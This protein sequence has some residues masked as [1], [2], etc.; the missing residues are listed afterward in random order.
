MLGRFDSTS[1]IHESGLQNAFIT[2]VVVI[3]SLLHSQ[4]RSRIVFQKNRGKPLDYHYTE[5]LM[6]Y[7]VCSQLASRIRNFS[8]GVN[9]PGYNQLRQQ[10][11]AQ[12]KQDTAVPSALP[13]Q[14]VH[15]LERK[16]SLISHLLES[17]QPLNLDENEEMRSVSGD[18]TESFNTVS[19]SEEEFES[20]GTS[21]DSEK[22]EKEEKEDEGV[23]SLMCGEW[24][25]R[26]KEQNTLWGREEIVSSSQ[27]S[28]E[29]ACKCVH[30]VLTGGFSCDA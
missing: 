13:T 10:F 12:F 25:V 17:Q 1:S 2:S 4:D 30:P 7:N 11:N 24:R 26:M 22:E 6:H 14:I 21:C 9:S 8:G 19:G 29:I 27:S 18:S 15:D 23:M 5:Y 16:S 3:F 20:V 28:K